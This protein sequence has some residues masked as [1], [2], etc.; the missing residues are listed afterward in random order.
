M[1]NN[2]DSELE[3]QIDEILEAKPDLIPPPDGLWESVHATWTGLW[4]DFHG[5]WDERQASDV[6][7]VV[8][9][10]SEEREEWLKTALTTLFNQKTEEAVKRLEGLKVDAEDNYTPE[11]QSDRAY[12]QAIDDAIK[13]IRE[14]K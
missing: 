5:E 10:L 6:F 2:K 13:T 11:S 12:N 9:L 4:T 14:G 3:K 8:D 7:P 1:S